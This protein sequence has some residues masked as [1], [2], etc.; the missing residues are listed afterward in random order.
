VLSLRANER[1][2]GPFFGIDEAFRFNFMDYEGRSSGL[3]F[4]ENLAVDIAGIR[5]R[6]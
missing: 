4:A 5:K 6:T 1:T 3:D 2:D